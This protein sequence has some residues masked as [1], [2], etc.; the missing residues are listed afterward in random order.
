[1][2]DS[3]VL[4]IYALCLWQL[5]KND[6]ALSTMRSLASSIL[7]LEET[8]AAAS[9]S[10]ICRLLY[11]ISGQESTITSILKMPKEFFRS[12]KISF[13]VTAIH[14]LDPKDQLEPV[15][16]RSRSFV[17]CREDI[18]R[19]HILITFGKLLKHGSNNSLGIQKGVDHLRKALHMY[20]NSSL[21]R[22][23]LSYLLLSSKEW[24]DLYLATRCSFL[25]LSDKQKYKGIKS[26]FEILGAGTVACYAIGSPKEKFPLPTCRHQHPSG[27]RAIQLLQKFLHQEPW[28]FNARYLLTLNCLQKARQERFA[29]QICRVL[30]RL[31]AV[32]LHNQFYSST[33]VSCQYQSFQLLLC[34][35]ELSLFAHLL[36]CRA[37]ATEDDII[38]ISKEYRQCLELGTDFHIGW[39]S[40]K[41]IE[42]R[43]QLGDD[44]T[45]LPL[46]F[47]DCCKDIKL[48]WNMWMAL[49]NMVQGLIAIWF[50]DFVAAEES[51]TQ[52]SSLADGESCILLCH[53]AICMELARQKCES[54]YISR[55]VRS[56]MKAKNASVDPLP[57]ISLLLAQA[58]ASLGSKAKWE[59]NLQNEWFSWPPE[60]T[61]LDIEN[62]QADFPAPVP[63]TMYPVSYSYCNVF[64]CPN[65][66]N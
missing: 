9:I 25:D 21:L 5:G 65:G 45:I 42:S 59:I 66:T 4:Q 18:I 57:I 29:P 2:L 36:L 62:R 51:L 58:E 24:R 28:N 22:N 38:S 15:V 8:L 13:V 1:Q 64:T 50:G 34:A 44:S 26:A 43:Y 30:E 27:S 47:E 19:M 17:T 49:F 55:A 33:D 46:C 41:F 48:S 54:Q 39:I 37:Y 52:A 14:V 60:M 32:A 3:E 35:A 20:P 10:F 40:L 11:H 53:G 16:S 6:M 12:S 7:S 61:V 56:L 31:T 23:L 63:W